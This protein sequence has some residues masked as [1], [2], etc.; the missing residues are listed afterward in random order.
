MS[1]KSFEK[2]ELNALRF[3][4]FDLRKGHTVGLQ[5]YVYCQNLPL[6]DFGGGYFLLELVEQC[7]DNRVQHLALRESYVS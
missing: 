2:S 5:M 4:C 6:V 1:L 3:S 7:E